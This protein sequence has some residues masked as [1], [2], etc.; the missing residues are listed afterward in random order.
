ML[1]CQ[2]N[3]NNDDT[4]NANLD[5]INRLVNRLD[6]CTSS[7]EQ[8]SDAAEIN[9]IL[10]ALKDHLTNPTIRNKLLSNKEITER[11]LPSIFNHFCKISITFSASLPNYL[12]F[13]TVLVQ[14]WNMICS[15]LGESIEKEILSAKEYYTTAMD[16]LNK[17]E[18]C[19]YLIGNDVED[20]F[21]FYVKIFLKIG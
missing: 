8:D 17:D 19:M 9:N 16:G 12:L 6:V 11:M 4:D 14:I 5:K 1:E 2:E 3:T 15:K 7:S 20:I 10:S 21:K 18:F 13:M